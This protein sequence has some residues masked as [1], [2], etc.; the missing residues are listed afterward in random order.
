[1]T[2]L[3]GFESLWSIVCCCLLVESKS[4]FAADVIAVT[5][6]RVG[7]EIWCSLT[8]WG[9]V[10]NAELGLWGGVVKSCL[11]KVFTGS[12]C[13]GPCCTVTTAAFDLMGVNPAC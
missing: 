5:L 3:S 8:D 2:D 13:N 1:M 6:D 12:V 10:C 7:N 9:A 11:D 4:G